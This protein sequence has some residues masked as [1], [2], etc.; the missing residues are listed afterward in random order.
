MGWQ[1]QQAQPVGQNQGIQ[2]G[3][4]G[5]HVILSPQQFL[6]S[7]TSNIHLDPPA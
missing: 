7:W 1:V 5:Q 3:K 4:L 6:L 2:A